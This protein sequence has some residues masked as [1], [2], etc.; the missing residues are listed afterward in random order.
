MNK[1]NAISR[2]GILQKMKKNAVVCELGVLRGVFAKKIF[3]LTSPEQLHLV[4]CW[5]PQKELGTIERVASHPQ[6]Q[7]D[8]WLKEAQGKF[9]GCNNVHFHRGFTTDIVNG[10]SDE[11]FDWIYIDADHTYEGCEADLRLYLPKMKKGGIMIADDYCDESVN[12]YGVKRAVDEF[13]LRHG[14][15]FEVVPKHVK[16]NTELFEAVIYL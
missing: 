12:Y 10:F 6:Q 11:Y 5:A 1:T 13:C 15:E 16:R 3:N 9:D 8:E 4:D 7:Y 14:F 2:E